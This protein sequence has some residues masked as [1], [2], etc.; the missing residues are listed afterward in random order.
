LL[1]PRATEHEENHERF[2]ERMG[3]RTMNAYP[4]LSNQIIGLLATPN[5][6]DSLPPKTAKAVLK[7]A[8][9]TRPGRKNFA[10]LR[11]QLYHGLLPTVRTSSA[12][13]ESA[14][15]VEAGNPK[16]RLETEIAMLPTPTTRD[17]KGA[18]KPETL[19]AAGRGITNTLEDALT[20]MLPTPRANKH[21]FPDSHGQTPLGAKRG[22]KLQPAFAAW[23][24]A[25]WKDPSHEVAIAT[26]FLEDTWPWNTVRGVLEA[27]GERA[28]IRDSVPG[29]CWSFRARDWPLI[30]PIPQVMPGEDHAIIQKLEAA[31]YVFAAL[32]LAEH[33]GV[34]HSAWNNQSHTWATPLDRARWGV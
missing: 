7:E 6:M 22:Y 15:E 5:T 20:A 19:A 17:W 30:G 4:T 14:A 10:N 26:L 21:G 33:T 16:R 3:D 8:T 1:T 11:D 34:E 9:V 24:M 29:G 25:C 32:D 2:V 28:L 18:R 13:G 23:M 31:G 27:G 12:N